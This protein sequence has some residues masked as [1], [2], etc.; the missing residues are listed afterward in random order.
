MKGV[1]ARRKFGAKV[2]K[3]MEKK[4]FEKLSLNFEERGWLR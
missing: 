2:M 4:Y 1:R 3:I